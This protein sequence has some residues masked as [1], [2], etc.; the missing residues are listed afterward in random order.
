[1]DEDVKLLSRPG[2][3]IILVFV[4]FDPERRYPIPRETPSAGAQST[5]GW[6]KFEIFDLNRRLSLK[7]FDKANVAME[8]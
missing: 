3:P 5:L 4:V 8:R 2:S 6:G 7:R 1:M